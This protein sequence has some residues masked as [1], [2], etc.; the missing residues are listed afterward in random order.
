M[1]ESPIHDAADAYVLP[2]ADVFLGAVGEAR[3]AIDMAALERA[4]AKGNAA[5]AML[6]IDPAIDAME[7]ALVA[8]PSPQK[9]VLGDGS[10]GALQTQTERAMKAGG[11][12]AEFC[13]K[14]DPPIVNV[15]TKGAVDKKT[16][17]SIKKSSEDIMLKFRQRFEAFENLQLYALRIHEGSVIPGMVTNQGKIDVLGVYSSSGRIDM[18]SGLPLAD[19]G[20]TTFGKWHVLPDNVP[21]VFR[22][23]LGHHVHA[24]LRFSVSGGTTDAG[25]EWDDLVHN[26]RWVRTSA[27][28]DPKMVV[29]QYAKTNPGEMFAESFAAYVHPAYGSMASEKLPVEIERYFEKWL[30]P[31]W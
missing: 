16:R 9:D 18:V 17:A 15:S 3:D 23:E 13:V 10:R 21:N 25:V 27:T 14:G 2:M 12:A 24:Q 5:A 7:A 29:S 31:R 11:E 22:H 26:H 4:C 6:V 1:A 20:L 8:I 19:E 30:K 28:P